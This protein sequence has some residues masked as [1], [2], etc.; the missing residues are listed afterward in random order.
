MADKIKELTDKILNEGVEKG[1]KQA[2][3]LVAEA[4]QKS[5]D[6]V[7]KAQAQAESILAEA[8]KQ[9]A[10]MKKNTES[11]MRLAAGQTVQ[12][13]KSTIADTIANKLAAKA[14][15]EVSKDPDYLRTLV[16]KIVQNW[17]VGE[18]M[19]LETADAQGLTAYLDA[20]MHELLAKG[21]EI[22]EVAGRATSY[23]LMPK[24]G[25]YKINFGDEELEA[26]FKSFMRPRLVEMLFS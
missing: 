12:S 19:V 11:E 9:A 22:K 21:L 23:T 18:P 8:R 4:E 25:S 17:K 20:N 16:G 13:L 24:D 6:I 2:N 5:K 10:E 14:A 1:K 15:A 7:D 3:A 26:F